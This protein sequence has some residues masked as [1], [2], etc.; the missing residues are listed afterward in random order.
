[1]DRT[2]I[3]TVKWALVGLALGASFAALP[4]VASEREGA[5][6]DEARLRWM[7]RFRNADEEQ[8]ERT[9]KAMEE[10]AARIRQAEDERLLR[11]TAPPGTDFGPTGIMVK[12]RDGNWVPADRRGRPL[13]PQRPERTPGEAEKA[14]REA[15]QRTREAFDRDHEKAT[16]DQARRDRAAREAADERLLR[17][18]PPPDADFGPT[19]I[20]VKDRAGNWV[21]AGLDGK[22]L[23]AARRPVDVAIAPGVLQPPRQPA[24]AAPGVE[25]RG[26]VIV[27]APRPVQPTMQ[28]TPARPATQARQA[29]QATQAAPATGAGAATLLNR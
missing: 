21:P 10:A 22:P 26:T 11:F 3:G 19:G 20:M 29:T 6:P 28:A 14:K 1:M 9:R 8:A 2:P 13:P 23:P 15:E 7:Q 25:P 18:T 5:D 24:V 12:D 16:R 17:Y 4:A 27:V